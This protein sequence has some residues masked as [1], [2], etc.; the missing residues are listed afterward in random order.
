MKL[1]AIIR[2]DNIST[3]IGIENK[4]HLQFVIIQISM[5]LI[6]NEMD[7]L[8]DDIKSTIDKIRECII[9]MT[10]NSRNRISIFLWSYLLI[11]RCCIHGTHKFGPKAAKKGIKGSRQIEEADILD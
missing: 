1:R 8:N 3:K 5:N 4:I 10:T 9:Q 11:R 7:Y 2:L 6:L